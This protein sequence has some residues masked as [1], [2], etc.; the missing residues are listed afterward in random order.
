MDKK[1]AL[2]DQGSRDEYGGGRP[3]KA[4]QVRPV[5][6]VSNIT[7]KRLQRCEFEKIEKVPS[8]SEFDYLHMSYYIIIIVTK[9]RYLYLSPL[10]KPEHKV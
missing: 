6:P 5:S 7:V 2:L 1:R 3:T 10:S 4:D 9:V 8:S